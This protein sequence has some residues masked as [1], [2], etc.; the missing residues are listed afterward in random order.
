LINL[1][2]CLFVFLSS[3]SGYTSTRFY[4]MLNNTNWLIN[5]LITSFLYPAI[6][7]TIFFIID[8]FLWAENSNSAVPFTTMLTLLVLWICCSTPLVLIGSFIGIKRTVIKNPGKVNVL[9]AHIPLQPWYLDYKFVCLIGGA[10]P[11]GAISIEL[12]YIMGSIWRHYFYYLFGFLLVVLLIMIITSAEISIV[13]IYFQ[14][15]K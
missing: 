14:L 9:P 8:L 3:L 2:I 15:C 4:K 13:V 11:F 10:I 1:S 5:A 7:F 12:I 6:S